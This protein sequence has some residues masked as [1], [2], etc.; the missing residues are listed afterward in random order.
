[1]LQKWWSL[2]LVLVDKEGNLI[3]TNK[4]ES[5]TK[6]SDL[7]NSLQNFL[8]KLAQEDFFADGATAPQPR[9]WKYGKT[10]ITV[11]PLFE[12]KNLKGFLCVPMIKSKIKEQVFDLLEMVLEGVE[13]DVLQTDISTPVFVGEDEAIQ[14]VRTLV[15]KIKD[16]ERPVLIEGE[17]GVGKKLLAKLIHSRSLRCDQ[18]ICVASCKEEDAEEVIFGSSEKEGLFL[19]SERGSLVLTD[20]EFAS[21]HL[22]SKL[23]RLVEKGKMPLDQSDEKTIDVRVIACTSKN[24]RE[25]AEKG[26]FRR[27]LY[28]SLNIIHV[29]LPALR[30][31]LEDI[32]YLIRH[33]LE[34]YGSSQVFTQGLIDK[35]FSHPW[36]GN[37][38]QLEN[39][40]KKM[41]SSTSSQ[42]EISEKDLSQEFFFEK[43]VELGH[44]EKL[45][46]SLEEL[47]RKIIVQGLE[48]TN[49]NRSQ[50]SRE[51]G[52]SRA[53]LLSKVQKYG[54]NKKN[55]S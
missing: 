44:V 12:E 27:D 9:D 23:L 31:R 18:R 49:G 43:K 48:R 6:K 25:L 55:V 17:N 37:V 45:K 40:I 41:I 24:L 10:D 1:M 47:E 4:K 13:N 22:Q 51:L 36:E 20:I 5:F 54:L 53:N 46:D 7:K 42:K 52:I 26:D 38:R 50:L 34:F 32:P 39:E 8:K 19:L 28:D 14:A 2:E 15:E 21:E 30:H 33:F 16:S 29:K 35:L 11:W 3:T